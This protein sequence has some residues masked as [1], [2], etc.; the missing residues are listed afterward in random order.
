MRL[1]IDTHI[2]YWALKS[3][4]RLSEDA[5]AALEN[6]NNDV[7]VSP[8]SL[9]ELQIKA[10]QNK[11]QLP[12]HFIDAINISGFRSLPITLEHANRIGQLPQIHKDPFD[13]I[14]VAQALEESLS[15]MTRDEIL[16]KY[17]VTTV[18]G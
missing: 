13:R 1:L 18:K 14:L 9:W 10:G 12:E 2:L 11:L 7:F 16:A 6:I 15:L 8:A 3:P 4:E 5:R 17:P